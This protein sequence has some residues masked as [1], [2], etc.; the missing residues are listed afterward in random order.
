MKSNFQ[1]IFAYL[2]FFSNSFNF[3]VIFRED[4]PKFYEILK[5]EIINLIES[6]PSTVE[7]ASLPVVETESVFSDYQKRS[8]I[9]SQSLIN[10]IDKTF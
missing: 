2:F 8:F 9:K 5:D 3:A 10:C 7:P 4:L 6:K 1:Q